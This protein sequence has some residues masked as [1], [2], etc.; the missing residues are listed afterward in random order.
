MHWSGEEWMLLITGVLFAAAAAA[1]TIRFVTLTLRSQLTFTVGAAAFIVAAIV[2]AQRTDVLYPPFLWLFPLLPAAIL[3][4]I[5]RD[6]LVTRRIGGA[7]G[8]SQAGSVVEAVDVRRSSVIPVAAATTGS[9]AA[10]LLR[11]RAADPTASPQELARIAY[12]HADMRAIVAGNPATPVS[13]LEWLA[14]VGDSNVHA[15]IS[16][17]RPAVA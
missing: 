9:P 14:S 13:L 10:R 3:G 6:A 4:V 11:M 7:A 12:A 16:T 2:L 1:G 15:A 5:V 17:R 8:A